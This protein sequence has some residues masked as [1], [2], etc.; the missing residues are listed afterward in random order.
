[1]MDIRGL[2]GVS[3][4]SATV[5]NNTAKGSLRKREFSLRKREF[6]PA[7]SPRGI[8]VHAVEVWQL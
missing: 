8:R 7:Y 6:I 3:D 5:I 2:A 4:L 1:M